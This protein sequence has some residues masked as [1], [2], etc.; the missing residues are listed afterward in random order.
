MGRISVM[1]EKG[2][3]RVS[4]QCRMF[5]LRDWFGDNLRL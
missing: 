1:G 5:T 2:A 4:L 3:D